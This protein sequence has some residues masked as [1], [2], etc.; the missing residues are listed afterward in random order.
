MYIP[1]NIKKYK[2]SLLTRFFHEVSKIE[3]KKL[4]QS[5]K[6]VKKAFF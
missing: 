3:N 2:K 6:L 1:K 5:N 4:E